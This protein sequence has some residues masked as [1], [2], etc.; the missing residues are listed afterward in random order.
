MFIY[1]SRKNTPPPT[2]LSPPPP[3]PAVELLNIKNASNILLKVSN[4]KA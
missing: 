3:P 4:T 1:C 2:R